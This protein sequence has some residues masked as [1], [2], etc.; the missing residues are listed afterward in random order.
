VNL[1]EQAVTTT[2][3]ITFS[4]PGLLTTGIKACRFLCPLAATIT[5]AYA[6]V[7]SAPSG[8]DL[9]F[10]IHLNGT[11]IWAAANRVTIA[12]DALSGVSTTFSSTSLVEGDYLDLYID[13]V[14]SSTAGS[15][16]TVELKTS[17]SIT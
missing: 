12:A 1:P 16:A 13:Q 15:N 14:G 6:V 2:P 9:I 4:V 5:K 11:T 7:M 8:A 3:T 10:D 17:L